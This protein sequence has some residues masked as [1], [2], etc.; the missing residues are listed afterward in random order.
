MIISQELRQTN[1]A[2]YILYMWQTEDQVRALRFNI[3]IIKEKIIDLYPA[4][5]NVKNNIK[6]WYESI[7][8]MMQLEGIEKV[9]HLQIMKNIVSDMYDLHLRLL[10][11]GKEYKYQKSYADALPHI[12][13]LR[14]RL[15]DESF[16]EIDV[17]LHGLY[18]IL[19]LKLK[20]VQIS[21]ETNDSVNSIKAMI[22][23]LASKY[24]EREKNP[25]KFFE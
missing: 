5:D 21:D 13:L 20:N 22:S 10:A 19:L 14:S 2:E 11:E 25:D 4:D 3:D 24:H 12:Q 8:S 9:G 6:L 15:T 17:S 7:I 23:I 16:N 1:I 18:G